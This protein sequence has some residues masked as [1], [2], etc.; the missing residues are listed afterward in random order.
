MKIPQKLEMNSGASEG[1][2]VP[3]IAFALHLTVTLQFSIISIIYSQV[4]QLKGTFLIS[5][6]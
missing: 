1:Y 6:Q 4:M 2:A 3:V 5:N